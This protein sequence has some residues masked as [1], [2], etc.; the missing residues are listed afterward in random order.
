VI[1]GDDAGLLL[2]MASASMLPSTYIFLLHAI[3]PHSQQ[4]EAED[5]ISCYTSYIS[6]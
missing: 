1:L 2:T 6:R 5:K 4:K 3:F